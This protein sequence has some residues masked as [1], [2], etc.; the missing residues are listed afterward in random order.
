MW[1]LPAF[2]LG[3]ISSMHCVGMCGPL[4]LS[5]ARGRWALSGYHFGR[6][7]VYVIFGAIAGLLGRGV[8]LAGFQQA[9]SVTLGVV[10]LVMVFGR[11]RIGLPGLSV[12]VGR[13]W[14]W[15]SRMKFLVLGMANGLL[16][17]G[18]VYL[19]LAAAISSSGVGHAAAFMAFFGLGTL[20]LLL[21]VSYFSRYIGVSVRARMRK[22]LPFVVASVGVLLILRG[23]GLGIPFVSPVLPAGPRGAISCH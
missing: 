2:A 23:M 5:V 1:L 20:P 21:A 12:L 3:M 15:E 16:P 8:R 10:I 19:A 7:G 11:W 17:C 18:M 9:F 13:L 22:V 14:R 6:I 4:V